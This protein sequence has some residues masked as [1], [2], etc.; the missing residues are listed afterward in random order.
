MF[1]K[2]CGSILVLILSSQMAVGACYSEQELLQARITRLRQLKQNKELGVTTSYSYTDQDSRTIKYENLPFSP[3]ALEMVQRNGGGVFLDA[4]EVFGPP[5]GLG[6]L[7][8]GFSQG[9]IL[10]ATQSSETSPF[11]RNLA[12]GLTGTGAAVGLVGAI[13]TIASS[14]NRSERRVQISSLTARLLDDAMITDM[15]VTP[16]RE[17]YLKQLESEGLQEFVESDQ[18]ITSIFKKVVGEYLRKRLSDSEPSMSTQRSS[19][20]IQFLAQKNLKDS[21]CK[22]LRKGQGF[23]LYLREMQ[24]VEMVLDP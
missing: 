3:Q 13:I 15:R 5:V 10:L 7:A 2:L 24:P 20:V 17:A 4:L 22:K 23:E 18:K 8:A 21:Q 6:I 19:E 16:E 11:G 9:L 1:R 14:G 12:I